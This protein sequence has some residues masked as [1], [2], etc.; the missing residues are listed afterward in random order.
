MSPDNAL[1]LPY[2]FEGRDSITK[3]IE[4]EPISGSSQPAS[5]SQSS[6][7]QGGKKK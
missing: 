4:E 7:S 6:Q 3:I 5:T 1:D 2:Q